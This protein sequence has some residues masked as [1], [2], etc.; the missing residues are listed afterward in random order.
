MIRENI[1]GHL[2]RLKWIISHLNKEDTIVELGC[3]TG[4][5]IT[6]PLSKLGFQI[7]GI[8]PDEKSISFGQALFRNEGIDPQILKAVD[9]TA[10]KMVPD[11][12]IA[13]EVIEHLPERDLP[14]VVKTIRRVL[15][16][17]GKLLVTVP[18]G[19]GW[20]EMEKWLW[21]KCGIGGALERTRGD[22]ICRKIKHRF[23]DAEPEDYTPSSLSNSPHVH[24]F[25]FRS[26]QQ[27]LLRYGFEVI[28]KV[29]SVLIAGPF[30]NLLFTG[31]RPIMNWN[32]IMGGKLPRL[33]AGF[34]IGS[35]LTNTN[36]LS[37]A[38]LREA[39]GR[40]NS[41]KYESASLSLAITT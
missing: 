7:I 40:S 1:Y 12:V 23:L 19:Y 5:M 31:L 38:S 15:K 27:L 22:M 2:K 16:P 34:F 10:L 4:R 18:N 17:G 8:D 24:R 20:F 33:A 30:S 29:G 35:R 37:N 21:F 14:V 3:G 26:I 9:M 36:A 25:T 13:S 39:E 11:V 6:L 41:S 28:D 32:N